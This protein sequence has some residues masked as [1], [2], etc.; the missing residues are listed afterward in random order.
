MPVALN[1]MRRREAGLTAML[2]SFA[3]H[4]VSRKKQY[5]TRTVVVHFLIGG[6]HSLGGH[7]RERGGHLSSYDDIRGTF[8]NWSV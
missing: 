3:S 2:P 1:S 5:R 6:P 7:S 4:D 8:S